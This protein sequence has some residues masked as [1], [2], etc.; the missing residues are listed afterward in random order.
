MTPCFF[1]MESFNGRT[2][3]F[4]GRTESF[5]GRTESFN[6]IRTKYLTQM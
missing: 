4:N 5:N 6:T 2:E 3:S 1:R